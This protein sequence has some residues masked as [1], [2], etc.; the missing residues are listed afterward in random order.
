MEATNLGHG[1]S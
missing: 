1:P